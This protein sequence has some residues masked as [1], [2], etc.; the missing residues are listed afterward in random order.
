M[1]IIVLAKVVPD[2]EVPSADFE[3]VGSRAHPRYTR[4]VGL[5]DENAVELGVQLKEKY[6]AE[7][8]IVSYGQN[9]DVQFLRKTLAMGGDKLVIVEGNSDDPFVIAANLKEAIASLGE[10]D[11]ILAGRQSSDMDR[12]V[13][14]GLVAGMLDYPFVPLA[15]T[16]ESMADGWKVSQL[17]ETG[18]RLM[19]LSGKAVL[20]IT[21]IP[22]NVPR[23][24]AVKAIFGAKKK[25][26]DKLPE[27]GAKKMAIAEVSVK[28]PKMESVCELIPAEDMEEA[29]CVLL[30]RLKEER[31]L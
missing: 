30:R 17:T 25:P 4:M 1:H 10:I 13:V 5:Y 3:L 6:D 12:G 31:Y 26:V 21:S 22:E 7:L 27:I 19:K 24:P 14:P 2:Y 23:I 29:A 20:S 28:I 15:C 11:L 18:K 9:D 8:T 16:V